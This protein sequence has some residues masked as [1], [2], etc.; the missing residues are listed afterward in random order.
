MQK[1]KCLITENSGFFLEY[2]LML[3]RPVLFFDDG[4]EKIHNND[5]KNFSDFMPLEVIFKNEFCQNFSMNDI[6]N[7][8]VLIDNSIKNFHSKIPQLN[9]LRNEHYYN[10]GKT[11]E[12]FEKILENQI[13][14][15]D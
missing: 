8:N 14:I 6:K 1:A 5:Y 13:L 2:M 4:I 10:F 9:N 12:K 7:I 15:K 11:I 3:N